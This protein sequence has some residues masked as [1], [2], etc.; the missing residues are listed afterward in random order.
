MDIYYNISDFEK[1]KC[2]DTTRKN[3]SITCLTFDDDIDCFPH[4][5]TTL[6]TI[7]GIWCSLNAIFGSFGNF[8]TLLTISY[9][10]RKKM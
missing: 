2:T 1:Q 10:L 4:H 8:V 5:N 3:K 7:V 9:G 6:S